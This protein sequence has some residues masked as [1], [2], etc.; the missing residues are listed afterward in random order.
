[1]KALV[2]GAEGMLGHKTFQT[3]L[4][5]YPETKCTILGSLSDPFYKKIDLFKTGSVVERVNAMDFSALESTLVK[6]RPEFIVNCAGIIKQRDE[7]KSSIPSIT[8]NSLL[9][10]KLAA[11]ARGW[12]GRVIHVSTDCVFNG[13]RGNYTESDF[14]DAE[15]LYGKSKSLGE[16]IAENALTLRT[17][18][19][20][21]ELSH[22]GSLLEWFLAQRGKT[23]RGFKRVIYSGVTT[24]YLSEIVSRIISEHP[25]LTGLYQVTSPAIPKYDLLRLLREAYCL[26]VDIQPDEREV[27]DR[28]MV[29][30]KFVRATGYKYPTWTDLIARLVDDSTPYEKW[31]D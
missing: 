12:D 1:M 27:S 5:R 7:S 29:G 21:R 6:L 28:S 17:S 14:S 18:I 8:L 15:D 19:I 9:P 24:N 11:F 20:G 4:A 13:R 23:I 31:R 30:D 3:L 10:H 26:D 22:F 25:T 16:V 2:L